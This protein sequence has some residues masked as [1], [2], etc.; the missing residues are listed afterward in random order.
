ML[1]P[2]ITLNL[3]YWDSQSPTAVLKKKMFWKLLENLQVKAYHGVFFSKV[4]S[5]FTLLKSLLKKQV[6]SHWFSEIFQ[7]SWFLEPLRRLPLM[8][9]RFEV[10]LSRLRT[11]LPNQHFPRLCSKKYHNL[12]LWCL[13]LKINEF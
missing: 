1:C 11:F 3:C 13:K 10:G 4:V 5:L 12:F 8:F 9:E 7:S 2:H 6:F